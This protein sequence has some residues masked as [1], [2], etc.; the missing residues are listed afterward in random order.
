MKRITLTL[1]DEEYNFLKTN[2]DA[3]NV[4]SFS[5]AFLVRDA[6]FY[7]FGKFGYPEPRLKT[8]AERNQKGRQKIKKG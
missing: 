7:N 6:L 4:P 1:T 3:I 5:M 8:H 2:V